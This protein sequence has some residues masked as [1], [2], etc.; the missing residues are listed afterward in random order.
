M[1]TMTEKG[2]DVVQ[3]LESQHEEVKSLFEAV[4]GSKGK[5]RERRFFELRRL[6]AIHETAEEEIVHPAASRGIPGGQAI[7]SARLAEEKEAKETLAKLELMNVDS[8]EFETLFRTL[9][10]KVLAHAEAEESEEFAQ[11]SGEL[12][13]ER[14]ER[15]RKAVELAESIAPTRPH[16]GIESATAN[17]LIGPFASMVDRARDALTSKR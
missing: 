16:P 3:F 1:G 17:L 8:T 12:E 2:I 13:R 11:L 6:L 15:M 7:V 9:H 14:L 4:V 10:E 5:S